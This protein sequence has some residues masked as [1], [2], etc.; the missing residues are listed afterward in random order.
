[1]AV[2]PATLTVLDTPP[3]N[4]LSLTCS[5]SQPREVNITK[6]LTW[7]QTNPSGTVTILTHNGNTVNISRVGLESS[8]SVST[9][10]VLPTLAGQ[11]R[12]TCVGSINIPGNPAISYSQ[13]A[14]V[15]VKGMI[16]FNNDH[17]KEFIP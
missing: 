7:E 5:V 10:S 14:E 11:W 9:I 15:T 13:S 16:K 17:C 3:Y 6:T 1:M 4:T 8:E 2:N 12:Y